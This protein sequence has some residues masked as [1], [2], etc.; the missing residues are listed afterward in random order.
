MRHPEA[1]PGVTEGPCSSQRVA[2]IQH[3]C[4]GDRRE[5]FPAQRPVCAETRGLERCAM[6]PPE[7]KT[8][9]VLCVRLKTSYQNRLLQRRVCSHIMQIQEGGRWI[10][11]GLIFCTEDPTLGQIRFHFLIPGKIPSG[12][13]AVLLEKLFTDHFHCP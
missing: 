5:P 2:N 9:L 10:S 11:A 12:P 8:S 13:R 1:W 6:W 4:S 7:T 3:F